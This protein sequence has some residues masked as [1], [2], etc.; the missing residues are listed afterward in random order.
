[1]LIPVC[2]P[3]ELHLPTFICSG[4]YLEM[5]LKE[6]GF[7]AGASWGR[8]RPRDPSSSCSCLHMYKQPLTPP[9]AGYRKQTQ[10]LGE[11][12]TAAAMYTSQPAP[13]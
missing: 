1:M 10:L 6:Q 3:T 7:K 8:Q 12:S 13:G 2:D 5:Q 11:L 9:Q 4:L